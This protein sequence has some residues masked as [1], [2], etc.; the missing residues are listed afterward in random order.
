[1]DLS[2]LITMIINLFLRKG[3]SKG[4]DYAAR[5]GK[6]PAAMTPEDHA[7]AKAARDLAKRA[8]QAANLAR[9]LGR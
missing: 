6:D 8:R 2:R 3:I 7:Q 5:R 1:M 9:K 4:I